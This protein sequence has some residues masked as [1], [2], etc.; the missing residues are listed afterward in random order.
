[1]ITLPIFPDDVFQVGDLFITKGQ[2]RK[3]VTELYPEIVTNY[4]HTKKPVNGQVERFYAWHS[5][6]GDINRIEGGAEQVINKLCDL[7]EL[8]DK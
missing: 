4:C 2:L 1:M 8:I 6:L 5:I 3:A 7:D